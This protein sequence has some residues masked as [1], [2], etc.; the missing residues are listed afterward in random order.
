MSNYRKAFTFKDT[1]WSKLRVEK[2]LSL[3]D[4]ADV[5]G[6]SDASI[7]QYFT[8]ATLP[9]DRTIRDICEL[10]DVDYNTGAHEFYKAHKAWRAEHENK[11]LK[12]SAREKKS[13]TKK[14]K[15]SKIEN[16]EDVIRFFYGQLS[17]DDFLNLYNT[18]T[19]TG[20][21][22]FE[23]ILASIYGT[24]DFETFNKINTIIQETRK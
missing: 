9:K 20:N 13:V 23:D 22:S 11:T 6:L 16:V 2:N 24:V 3:Q 8:G 5:I 7:G 14:T 1:F 21:I 12:Y 15:S 18:L 19:G 4:V 10:F 17:C